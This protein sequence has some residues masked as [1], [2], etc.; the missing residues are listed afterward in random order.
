MMQ[1]VEIC[2]RRSASADKEDKENGKEIKDIKKVVKEIKE[3]EKVIKRDQ[4]IRET[5]KDR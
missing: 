2:D 5:E 4:G 3:I 1:K